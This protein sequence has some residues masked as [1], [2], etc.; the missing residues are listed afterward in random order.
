MKKLFIALLIPLSL[1]ASIQSRAQS[2]TPG[3]KG[4]DLRGNDAV[5][6]SDY[7]AAMQLFQQAAD[8]GYAPAQ[9]DIGWLYSRGLGV[10]EDPEVAASW[11]L[12]AA[13]GGYTLAQSNLGWFYQAGIGVPRD[14]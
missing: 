3:A 1:V 5:R 7:T 4:L 8:Q 2:D 9:S 10:P 6:Q 13:N 12:K 14:Y 11:Y